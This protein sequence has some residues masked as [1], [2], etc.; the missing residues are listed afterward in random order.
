MRLI[1]LPI[2]AATAVSEEEKRGFSG[3]KPCRTSGGGTE[4]PTHC[5]VLNSIWCNLVQELLLH[6]GRL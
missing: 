5:S 6:A 1:I 4:V 3:F 2:L